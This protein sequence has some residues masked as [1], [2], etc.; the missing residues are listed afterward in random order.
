MG[1]LPLTVGLI[2]A[3]LVVLLMFLS[4]CKRLIK[5]EPENARAGYIAIRAF[6]HCCLDAS[7][8]SYAVTEAPVSKGG[9]AIP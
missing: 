9:T 5:Y 1:D 7:R 2:S 4:H 8:M 3:D 6:M